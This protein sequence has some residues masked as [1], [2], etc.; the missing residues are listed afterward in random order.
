[1]KEY[2]VDF[3]DY[4]EDQVYTAIDLLP[5]YNEENED[6]KSVQVRKVYNNLQTMEEKLGYIVY[7]KAI[8]AVGDKE[9]ENITLMMLQRTM[10]HIMRCLVS[11]PKNTALIN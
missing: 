3:K 5:A 4:E 11:S 2:D 1:M 7:L 10:R 8:F 6:K 9:E